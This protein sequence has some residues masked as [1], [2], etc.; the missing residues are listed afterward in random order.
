MWL[1]LRWVI[2]RLVILT[3]FALI[4]T[5]LFND[6]LY[7]HVGPLH[8]PQTRR[9]LRD[10]REA[11]AWNQKDWTFWSTPQRPAQLVP[12]DHISI[13]S[14]NISFC[15]PVTVVITIHSLCKSFQKCSR[16]PPPHFLLCLT[17]CLLFILQDN[18]GKPA[19]RHSSSGSWGRGSI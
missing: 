6:V 18:T 14:P 10:D 13:C 1:L 7:T 5:D 17:H 11:V 16:L 3:V 15:S 12:S 8:Q 19:G 2:K 9:D 4:C